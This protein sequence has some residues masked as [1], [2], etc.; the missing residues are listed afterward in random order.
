MPTGTPGVMLIEDEWLCYT[1]EDMVRQDGPK[2]PGKTAIPSGRY[3]YYL[4][5]S[6]RFSRLMPSIGNVNG[7]VGIRTHGGETI[8][9]TEGCPLTCFDR[10]DKDGLIL[11]HTTSA[12]NAICELLKRPGQ[13]WIE[14]INRYPYRSIPEAAV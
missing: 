5:F 14:I 4:D 2:V 7:F 11:D 6:P 10:K 9:N 12:T 1:L 8:E 3:A 13:H